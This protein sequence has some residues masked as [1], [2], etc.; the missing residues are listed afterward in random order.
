ME[1]PRVTRRQGRSPRLCDTRNQGIPDIDYSSG[2]LPGSRYHS[3]LNGRRVIQRQY[4][5][6]QFRIEHPGKGRFQ[7][8]PALSIG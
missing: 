7:S 3:S 6:A 4:P 2:L 5:V 1:M 8:L